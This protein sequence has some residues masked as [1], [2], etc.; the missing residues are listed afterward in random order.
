[1][2][3]SLLVVLLLVAAVQGQALAAPSV[4]NVTVK[5]ARVHLGDVL[6]GLDAAVANVDMGP[7]PAS[8]GTRIVTR[9]EIA[10]AL[11]EHGIDG[12]TTLPS[13]VRVHRKLRMLDAAEIGRV[14]GEG[15][16]AHPARGTTLAGVRAPKTTPVPDGWTD[17]RCDLPH[18]PHKAGPF[19]SAVT[20]TWFD[21]TQALWTVNVPVDLVL[22]DEAAVYDVPR[23]S[24]VNFVIR[25]G[26]IEVTAKGTTTTDADIGGVA[27]VLVMPSGRSLPARLE[28][29]QTAVMLETP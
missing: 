22:S 6:A 2:R 9:D 27:P 8:S 1:M 24:H 3:K 20:I 28:D 17:V 5:G 21:G 4:V 19:A 18:P 7:S 12:S 15:L 29:A 26:L 13:A 16:E 23:G 25:R 10:Q 14:V 11:H